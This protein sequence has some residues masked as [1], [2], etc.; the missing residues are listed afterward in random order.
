MSVD[1]LSRLA[2]EAGFVFKGRI[3][4]QERGDAET[5]ADTERETLDV[6]VE[7]VLIGTDVTR[8]LVGSEVTVVRDQGAESAEGDTRVFFTDVVSLGDEVV[9]REVEQR[10]ASP[11]TMRDVAEGVRIVAE[12][13]VAERIAGAELVVTGRVTSTRAIARESPPLSEHDPEWS[14][15]R[16]SVDAVLKGPRSRRTVEVLFASSMDIAWYRSPKLDEGVSGIFILR[17]RDD[18]EAPDEVGANVFQ[19]TH[20]L[21]FLPHDR[22]GDVQRMT[23]EDAGAA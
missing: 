8:G 2:D 23:R 6:E 13:P 11:A 12:R 3:V 22:L 21:D 9:V 15:A 18:D 20:P 16:V 10:D 17:R 4:P 5:A 7:E 19:A 1:E 14:I